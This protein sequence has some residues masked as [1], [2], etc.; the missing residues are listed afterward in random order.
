MSLALI[1]RQ[2]APISSKRPAFSRRLGVRTTCPASRSPSSSAEVGRQFAIGAW[3]PATS[4]ASSKHIGAPGWCAVCPGPRG[5]RGGIAQ[6][7]PPRRS[8]RPGRSGWDRRAWA[9]ASAALC[10]ADAAAAWA[11]A[12]RVAIL[13]FRLQPAAGLQPHQRTQHQRALPRKAPG[14][15]QAAPGAAGPPKKRQQRCP[16]PRA[17]NARLGQAGPA[18]QQRDCGR[19]LSG[20][21]S[22]LRVGHQRQPQ[23]SQRRVALE[24][25]FESGETAGRH[26]GAE[27]AVPIRQ[28]RPRRPQQR[29]GPEPAA[30][31]RGRWL[32]P[33][34]IRCIGGV[35]FSMGA[36]Q[37]PE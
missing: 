19:A 37:A 10:S 27:P 14:P 32:R 4:W 25:V 22:P 31:W 9:R 34:A 29:K 2:F 26:Q 3:H 17:S 8:A 5:N 24:G 33:L 30:R 13:D 20:A 1:A 28:A 23:G 16:A 11:A 21:R 35:P 7:V 15:A 6:P 12:A 36:F 18:C